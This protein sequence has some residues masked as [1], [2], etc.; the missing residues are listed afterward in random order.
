MVN[1][2]DFTYS[3]GY[4]GLLSAL[5]ASLGIT[6]CCALVMP[7]VYNYVYDHCRQ[8]YLQRKKMVT[9]QGHW[10]GADLV[11]LSCRVPVDEEN[12]GTKSGTP[13]ETSLAMTDH[14]ATETHG[15]SA[16][17]SVD[18]CDAGSNPPSDSGLRCNH[19]FLGV[20]EA[21]IPR[22]RALS[23]SSQSSKQSSSQVD[24]P[25]I[26]HEDSEFVPLSPL[27][28]KE[29]QRYSQGAQW[30]GPVIQRPAL[31]KLKLSR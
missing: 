28:E 27:A 23:I 20:S 13:H 24:G 11:L 19:T 14:N 29:A 8:A 15:G 21:F 18:S 2:D 12:S 4:L 3:K 7:S 25:R 10:E 16:R 22:C 9:R 31:V 1:A 6:C 26:Q 5:G 17:F 30:S